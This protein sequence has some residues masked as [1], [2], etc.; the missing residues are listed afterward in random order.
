[1][2]K[3]LLTGDGGEWGI[4]PGRAA[5][6]DL[7]GAVVSGDLMM[8]FDE[9]Q[10]PG[11][12]M[13]AC[14]FDGYARFDGVTFTDVA[15]FDGVTFTDVARFDGATFTGHAQF[16]GA[17]FAGDAWFDDAT[18]IGG[19]LFLGATFAGDAKFIAATFIGGAGF[20]EATFK[21]VAQFPGATFSGGGAGFGDATFKGVAEFFEATFTTSYALFRGATFT[22]D[23]WFVG[24]TFNGGALFSGATFTR[25]ARFDNSLA[26]HWDF[27]SATFVAHD[28][29]PWIASKVSLDRAVLTVR[30]RISITATEIGA[31]RLQAREGA[32]LVLHCPRVDLSDSE[33]LRRSI[34]SSPAGAE[35][36]PARNTPEEPSGDSPQEDARAAAAKAAKELRDE[37]V[38]A[39]AKWKISS[40]GVNIARRLWDQQEEMRRT[41]EAV[42]GTPRSRVT[43]LKRANIG[44]LVLSDVIL[45]DCEFVGAHGLDK[46]RIGPGCSFQPTPRRLGRRLL[47]RRRIIAEELRWRQAHTGGGKTGNAD[48]LPAPEIA[49]IYRDLRKGLEEAKNEPG[50]A[51]FYYGEME[52]RRLAGR[53]PTG[54]TAAS[55]RGA[56]SWAERALLNGY[57]AVSGYGLRASRALITLVVVLIGAALLYTSPAFATVTPPTA[58]IAMINP[59]TGVVT[60]TSPPPAAAPGLSTAL[61]YSL[62]ESISLLQ[63]RSTSAITTTAAGTVLDFVLRLT[64][65]V[66]L[67]FTVLALRA[68]IKR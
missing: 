66:L 3:A 34:V 33:F 14:R 11:L 23:A 65:P 50:A 47:G 41:Y 45:D 8:G 51:D 61:E 55:R 6:V 63:T 25:D 29:G 13:P 15:R 1:V 38:S 20:D 59:T 62:R 26:R 10:L 24:A 19:A 27:T 4:E 43:S 36:I 18:F 48:L 22:R 32:H 39:F 46:L 67:A 28:P 12:R 5:A 31:S 52:M 42:H 56:P 37:L 58:Q 53:K 60:Y 30:S 57:W 35:E 7:R 68:R 40:T 17:T 9:K 44:E 16:L 64:G 49:A 54:G 21:G 2:L